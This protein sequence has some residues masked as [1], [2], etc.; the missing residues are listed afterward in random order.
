MDSILEFF[1]FILSPIQMFFVGV[2]TQLHTAFTYVATFVMT[3]LQ[4]VINVI[5][6]IV[7]LFNF[8]NY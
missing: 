3:F 1:S 2:Y 8:G 7:D 6:A 4:G 5:Q